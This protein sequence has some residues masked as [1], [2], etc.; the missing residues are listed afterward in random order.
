MHKLFF[1]EGGFHLFDGVFLGVFGDV[2]VGLHGLVVAVAGEFH[3]N[4]RRDSVGEGEADEGLSAGVRSDE[5]VF[6]E[7][8]VVAGAVLV[9]GDR[10]GSCGAGNRTKK[11]CR[12][13]LTNL[14]PSWYFCRNSGVF[15]GKI[16]E[17]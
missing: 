8:G 6:G 1:S 9:A 14:A 5:G 10:V 16:V 15:S 2:D 7:D 11:N 3:N 4:V 13:L 17:I 12:F